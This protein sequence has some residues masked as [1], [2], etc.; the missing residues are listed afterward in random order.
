MV[1]VGPVGVMAGLLRSVLAAAGVEV[2]WHRHPGGLAHE[3]SVDAIVLAGLDAVDATAALRRVTAAPL[4]VV[5]A[6]EH[7]AA[8][9]LEIGADALLPPGAAPELVAAQAQAVLRRRVREE[10]LGDIS[11]GRLRM[12]VT[13]RRVVVDSVEVAL[14]PR[15]FDL[16]G[17]FLRNPGTVLTRDR[18]LAGAWGPRFVGEPKTVDVHIAWLRPKLEG[19]GLRVTTLRGVGYRLDVLEELAPPPAWAGAAATPAET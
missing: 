14:T 11:L 7:Q 4:I 5:G 10:R 1:V 13:A 16:L 12:E 19:S 6:E 8:A 9:C 18:I 15:E 2:A 3:P 17:V